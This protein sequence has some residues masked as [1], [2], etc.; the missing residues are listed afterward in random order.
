MKSMRCVEH[1][2]H[3]AEMKNAHANV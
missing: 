2:A 3:M 1:G